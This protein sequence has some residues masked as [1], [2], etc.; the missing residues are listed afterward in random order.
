MARPRTLVYPLLGVTAVAVVAAAVV[1]W[2]NQA[3]PGPITGKTTQEREPETPRATPLGEPSGCSKRR[4]LIAFVS[5]H[6][7]KHAIHVVDSRG[8]R[9]V[10]SLIRARGWASDPAWSPD[11]RRIA[12]RLFQPGQARPDIYVAR[13]NGA[14][15]TPLVD[16]AAMPSWSPGGR[17]LA[18]ANLR[19]GQRG[20][21]VVNVS[22][23]LRGESDVR[24]VT[25]V[26]DDIPE[27]QPAW[28]PD[29]KQI[30]FTSQRDGTSDIWVV[31]ARG[32]E[33]RNLTNHP[34]LDN[35]AAWSPD[36]KYIAFGST[37]DSGSME[38]GDIYVM[39]SDGSN[40]RRI[41]TGQAS[42]SPR[43]S[44]MVV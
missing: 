39:D 43:W 24:I 15:S 20:I 14:G 33:P 38:G 4:Y 28:S 5:T 9:R 29:G 6:T 23:G 42:Y 36:G 30:A 44:P 25:R 12:F 37:R 2:S 8:A 10:R 13:A 19:E 3:P 18:F 21:S 17:S 34:G 11:G 31:D 7:G 1:L 35:S 16:Q 41:T 40:V 27:E 32:G 22:E 26:S